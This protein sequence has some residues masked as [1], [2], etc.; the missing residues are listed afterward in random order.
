MVLLMLGLLGFLFLGSRAAENYLR[1]NLTVQ[2]FMQPNLSETQLREFETTLKSQDFASSISYTSKERAAIEF[3]NELGQDF[4]GFL[5]YN[6]LM[7]SF[8]VKLNPG[9]NEPEK[10]MELEKRIKLIGG[11]T[12]VNYP[13]AAFGDAREN[14][15]KVGGLFIGLA[16]VFGLIAAVLIHNTVRLNLYAR[17][18]TIKSMQLVG[19]THWFIIK[20]FVIRGFINGIWGWIIAS[21]LLLGIN[22]LIPAWIP[23]WQQFMGVMVNL[24]LVMILLIIGVSLSVASSFLSTRKFLNTRLDDLY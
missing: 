3:A 13:K 1:E 6:P 20:P 10:L 2:V 24:S 9:W 18:F 23:E 16:I 12:D 19:A 11:V 7:A 8:Q 21:L 14:I 15:R 5:G 4:V 22:N 17:R